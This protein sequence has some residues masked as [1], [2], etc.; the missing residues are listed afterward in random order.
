MSS[1][2]DYNLNDQIYEN[3]DKTISIF[4]TRKTGTIKYIAVKVYNKKNLKDKYNYEYN[5][6]NKIKNEAIVNISSCSEDKNYFY[7]EMEYCSTG[8]LA[9]CI[10]QNKSNLYTETTIKL[11]S[12]QLLSGLQALHKNGIIH[13][14]LKPS[15]ILIDEYGNAKICDFKKCL[16][17]STMNSNLV[18]K[19]K[20]KMTP[21]YTAPELFQEEGEYSFKSDLWSLG[22]IMYELSTGQVPFLD[23]SIAKL[24]KK[25]IYDNVNFKKIEL[26]NY[27]DDFI[28]V[29]KKLL[30][31]EPNERATWGDIEKM[32]WW[33]GYFKDVKTEDNIENDPSSVNAKNCNINTQIDPLKLTKIAIENKIDEKQD[34][35]N[36]KVDEICSVDQE[37][38]FQSKDLEDLDVNL[39]TNAY[40][41][42]NF[43]LKAEIKLPKNVIVL[44]IRKVFQKR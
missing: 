24:V 17:V 35:N 32:P 7:M 10:W 38:D 8:D 11:I 15:N 13:C 19:N 40:S 22:C 20:S 4:K 6:M 9:K 29:L 16:K 26:S 34:Y 27:S 18:K 2:I 23:N 43:D 31:K 21:C 33:N 37:F 3:H 39:N 25:I 44:K 41:W 28:E 12:T 42:P 30:V 36:D 1:N 5:L 14:N